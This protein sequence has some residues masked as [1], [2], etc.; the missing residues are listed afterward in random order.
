MNW[1]GVSV[2]VLRSVATAIS[3]VERMYS[4]SA[5]PSP[6]AAPVTEGNLN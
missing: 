3:P 2:E 6:D 1:R 4:V 5:R